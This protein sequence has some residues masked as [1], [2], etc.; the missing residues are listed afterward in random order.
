ML[1][2]VSKMKLHLQILSTLCNACTPTV[3]KVGPN[4]TCAAMMKFG[5]SIRYLLCYVSLQ[6]DMAN[7]RL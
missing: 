6:G 7:Q 3:G 5:H 1:S 4:F 2:Y